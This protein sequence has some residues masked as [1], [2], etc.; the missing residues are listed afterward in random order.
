MCTA[1]THWNDPLKKLPPN[2]KKV[3]VAYKNS[4]SKLRRTTAEYVF[5]RTIPVE[6]FFEWEDDRQGYRDVDE[7]GQEWVVSGWWEAP[8]EVE[9]SLPISDEILAWIELPELPCN[10]RKS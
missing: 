3:L 10:W 2:G 8:T 7:H 9:E 1:W 6:D 5:P 4:L